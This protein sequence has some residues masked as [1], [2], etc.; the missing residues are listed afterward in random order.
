MSA[1]LL[2]YRLNNIDVTSGGH[3]LIALCGITRVDN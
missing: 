2:T 1:G 3:G